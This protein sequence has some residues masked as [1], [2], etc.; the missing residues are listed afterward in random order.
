MKQQRG[1]SRELPL[2]T[3][4]TL[5]FLLLLHSTTRGQSANAPHLY[6][7]L[8][9]SAGTSSIG[10]AL[11]N[12]TLESVEVK[13]TARSYGGDLIAGKDIVNLDACCRERHESFSKRPRSLRWDG[14]SYLEFVQ[15]HYF[16][17]TRPQRHSDSPPTAAFCSRP[18]PGVATMS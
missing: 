2:K 8:I 15:C 16:L 18:G 7:P 13:L 9:Q 1:N 3:L 4:A 11:T 17:A 14:R 5:V 6:L 10:I 12:P